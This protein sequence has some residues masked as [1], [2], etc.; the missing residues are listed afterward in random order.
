MSVLV[1]NGRTRRSDAYGSFHFACEPA[2]WHFCTAL[3]QR[4]GY[5]MFQELICVV[6]IAVICVV[7]I[8]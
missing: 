8:Q 7:L 5:E 4:R 2:R 3:R 6:L 1:T